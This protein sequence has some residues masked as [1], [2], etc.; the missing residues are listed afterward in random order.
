MQHSPSWEANWFAASPEIPRILRNPKVHYRSQKF[1]PPVPILS[2]LDAVHIPISYF[3]KTHLNIIFPSTPGSPKW[4]FPSSFPTKTLSSPHKCYMS[5]PSL[6][7][8][9]DNPNNNVWVYRSL[10][11]SLRNFL[12]SLLNSSLLGPNIFLNTPFTHEALLGN[13][14]TKKIAVVV[15]GPH[16]DLWNNLWHPNWPNTQEVTSGNQ[17]GHK[18]RRTCQ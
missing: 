3:L 16:V 12:H 17:K 15:R 5:R 14:M 8:R 7:S 2:Q 9:C 18:K 13:K 4:L 6:F 11:S 1:P 10:S